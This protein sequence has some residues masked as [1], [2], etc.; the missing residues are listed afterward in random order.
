MGFSAPP[1]GPAELARLD[2]AMARRD[3]R[4]R[5][6]KIND[7]VRVWWFGFCRRVAERWGLKRE[8]KAKRTKAQQE[9]RKLT[10][11]ARR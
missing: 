11:E 5:T 7:A 6:Q 9:L 2:E 8:K 10:W 3:P 1:P 4:H